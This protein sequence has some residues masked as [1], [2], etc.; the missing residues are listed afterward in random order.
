MYI[1]TEDVFMKVLKV[2]AF[3]FGPIPADIDDDVKHNNKVCKK[4]DVPFEFVADTSWVGTPRE[5][6]IKKDNLILELAKT[7]PQTLFIDPDYRLESVPEFPDDD[8]PHFSNSTGC[9]CVAGIF[10]NGNTEFFD[11]YKIECERRGIDWE[12]TYGAPQKW[13]RKFSANEVGIIPI[14]TYNHRARKNGGKNDQARKAEHAAKFAE[15][16][17]KSGTAQNSGPVVAG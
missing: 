16:G 13:L 3:W 1:S 12:H 8:R 5:A 17:S 10:P 2:K 14:D 9:V 15:T 4:A 7:E 6:A 11:D